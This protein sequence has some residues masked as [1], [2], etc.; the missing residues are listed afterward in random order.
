MGMEDKPYNTDHLVVDVRHMAEYLFDIEVGARQGLRFA[1]EGFR[2]VIDE[3]RAN[4]TNFGERAG[5]SQR[6]FELLLT[7]LE[8]YD[9]I[10]RH[11][12]RARKIAEKLEESHAIADDKLQRMVFAFAHVIEA[13][14]RGF[15][16]PEL[17]A[18]YERVRAYRSA[19][20]LKAARTRRRK[21]A[22][23]E[24][25]QNDQQPDEQPDAP[26]ELPP[27]VETAR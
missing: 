7:E 16:D 18:V 22:E 23:L 10:E 5:I 3:F 11:M 4:Q 12:Y 17:L 26:A 19:V 27:A 21:E 15:D 13:R 8:R 25:P 9:E 14:A 20:G 24:N 2:E 6:D 1:Q